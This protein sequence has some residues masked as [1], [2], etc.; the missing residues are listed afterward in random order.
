MLNI[1][2]LCPAPRGL[3]I[4]YLDPPAVDDV[5]ETSRF[6]KTED[7][8]CIAY[9]VGGRASLVVMAITDNGDCVPAKETEG[10]I[11]TC[12]EDDKEGLDRFETLAKKAY[13]STIGK[14][15]VDVHE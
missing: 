11:G 2:L 12:W 8:A 13:F 3:V 14:G 5:D 15:I 6:T 7:A 9:L 4:V 1:G 10:F